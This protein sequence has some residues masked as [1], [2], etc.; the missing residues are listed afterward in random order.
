V[1]GEISLEVLEGEVTAPADLQG[2]TWRKV[3]QEE[4]VKTQWQQ[5]TM[6]DLKW[7]CWWVPSYYNSHSFLL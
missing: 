7:W 4:G 6:M 2:K 3:T 5:E 1:G